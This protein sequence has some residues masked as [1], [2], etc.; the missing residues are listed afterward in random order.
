MLDASERGETR[1][2]RHVAR[3]LETF[4]PLTPFDVRLEG[5][6]VDREERPLRPRVVAFRP[7][8][9]R[10]PKVYVRLEGFSH[11]ENLVVFR[12]RAPKN[13]FS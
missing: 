1:N 10:A 9:R 13:A 5:L 8:F 11:P 3:S 12:R 7:L 4:L 6:R 2:S